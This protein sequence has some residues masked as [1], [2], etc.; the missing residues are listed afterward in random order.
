MA[1][2]GNRPLRILTPLQMITQDNWPGETPVEF[3]YAQDQAEVVAKISDVDILLSFEFT[4]EMAAAA[5][6]LKLI[7]CAGA[8]YDKIDFAAVPEG[9][10]VVNVYEHEGPIAE[11]VIMSMIALDREL[12]KA[13]RTLR[14]GSWEMS[15][16]HNNFY[17]ELEGRTLGIVGLGRI[18]RRTAALATAF[19]MRL[20]AATRTV[21]SEAE[22]RSLGFDRVVGLERLDLIL[23]EADFLLLSLALTEA[24]QGIIGER[25]LAIMKPTANLINVARAEVADEQ[26]L[27]MALKARQIKG[28]ALDV[29]YHEPTG[30]YE[31]P[32][33]ASQPFWELDNVIMSPHISGV[34]TGLL[35]RRLIATAKNIDRLARGEPL[36]NV[37]Q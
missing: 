17:P 5:N 27:F 21:P 14:A 31:A 8:G 20:I 19:N 35:R 10:V 23:S 13:D 16:W 7:H 11:W 34:T 12:I 32:M 28:A 6:Q 1:R 2:T 33:P 15:P 30:G 4:K 18:G 24:T 26:A 36:L 3:I 29:W 22:A 25:E 37:I 9:C